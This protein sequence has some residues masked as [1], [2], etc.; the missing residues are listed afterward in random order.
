MNHGEL[1]RKA[2]KCFAL[3]TALFAFLAAVGCMT[4]QQAVMSAAGDVARTQGLTIDPAGDKCS[5]F[6]C[7]P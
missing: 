5:Q 6:G 3:A 7:E 4:R 2:M 1:F